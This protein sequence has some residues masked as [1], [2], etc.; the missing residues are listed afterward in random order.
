MHEDALKFIP[1][2]TSK[3]ETMI[4]KILL[5]I[6]S[7]ALVLVSHASLS[8][9][10]DG[11]F[12]TISGT[13][14]N[15][16]ADSFQLKS[17]D[18]IIFVEMDDNDWDADGYKLVNGDEVVVNGVVDKDFLEKKKIEAGSVYVKGLNTYFYA[19]SMD[20]EG[21]PFLSP[22]YANIATLPEHTVV[23]LTG[24][25]TNINNRTFTV[26]TG[27]REIV[28]DTKSLIYNPMDDKGFTQIDLGDRVNVTG[29]ISDN[30]FDQR[31]VDASSLYEV[32]NAEIKAE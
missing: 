3:E 20:E 12:V 25:V 23:E 11:E 21:A 14:K 31:Q 26:N 2:L 30:F 18:H 6:T 19:S 29:D 13:V 4:S 15:V 24:K 28:V 27:L 5:T 16:K 17:K 7:L 8:A 1:R 32:E 22:T 10:K 9:K